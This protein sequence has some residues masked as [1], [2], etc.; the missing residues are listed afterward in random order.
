[1]MINRCGDTNYGQNLW[2]GVGCRENV[3]VLLSIRHH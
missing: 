3:P 2:C 1:M